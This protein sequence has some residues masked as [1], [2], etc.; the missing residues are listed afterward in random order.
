MIF[1]KVLQEADSIKTQES[2]QVPP[3]NPRITTRV[4]NGVLH[5]S[6]PAVKQVVDRLQ[7]ELAGDPA[8]AATFQKN[9]RAV[10]GEMGLNGDVQREIL[11][12][13]GLPVPPALARGCWG[14]C[15]FTRCVITKIVIVRKK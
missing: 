3:Q 5:P 13:A 7:S 12:D 14:T 9:P 8:F 6:L 11:Q 15:W 10:L 1:P 4:V 2:N